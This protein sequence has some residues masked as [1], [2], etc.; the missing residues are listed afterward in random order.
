MKLIC[1]LLGLMVAAAL[2][3]DEP[4]ATNSL[5]ATHITSDSVE[6]DMKARVAT[7]HGNVRVADPSIT[8]TCEFLTAKVPASGRVESIVAETNVVAVIVT[9]STTFT[10]TAARAVYLYQVL[11][12]ATN[13]TLELTGEPEPKITW[14]Q[15]N[16]DPVHTN[17]FAARRIVW[18]LN[19]N[20]VKA[21]SHRGVFPDMEAMRKRVAQPK[22]PSATNKTAEP[23]P[24]TP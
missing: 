19:K 23:K 11:P 7:Y 14:P 2:W 12:F 24:A 15:E 18:D 17:E 6:F 21:D 20:T 1:T 10:V 4:S 5:S 3:A 8:M 13:Q 22:D 16:S 9:N